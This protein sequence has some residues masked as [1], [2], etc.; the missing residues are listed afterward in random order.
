MKRRSMIAALGAVLGLPVAL[1]GKRK[2]A[3]TVSMKDLTFEGN[4]TTVLT[5]EN[6]QM[7]IDTMRRLNTPRYAVV[8]PCDP[9][10]WGNHYPVGSRFYDERGQMYVLQESGWWMCSDV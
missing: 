4:A 7:A 2:K 3:Y 5:H 1:W 10:D 8:E 9:F 6:L